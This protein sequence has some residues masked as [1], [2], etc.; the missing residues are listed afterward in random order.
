VSERN[1][2]TS[3]LP[4]QRQALANRANEALAK[5]GLADLEL[6]ANAEVWFKK[7]KELYTAGLTNCSVDQFRLSLEQFFACLQ[8]AANLDSRHPGIQLWL[9]ISYRDALGTEEDKTAAAKWLRKA[10]EQG[11]VEAQYALANI[12]VNSAPQEVA[13][14]MILYRNAAEQNHIDAQLALG[15]AYADGSGGSRN[16]VESA[17]WFRQA[18]E[19]NSSIGQYFLAEA[20]EH[21]RGVTQDN[22]AAANWYRKAAEQ[23][24]APAQYRLGLMYKKGD[25]VALDLNEAVK[26]FSMASDKEYQPAQF[27]IGHMCLY[28]EWF[29]KDYLK[30]SHHLHKAA[31]IGDS[32]DE[33]ILGV[34]LIAQLELAHM[35]SR[36]WGV[37][38][39]AALSQKWFQKSVATQQALNKLRPNRATD[40]AR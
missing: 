37:K 2:R 12:L 22:N 1:S 30:A 15:V 14:A 4:A 28:G 25:G 3:L 40:A 24:M 11:V 35:Y 32:L 7:A 26:W 23:D 34:A 36:G 27:Q 9:G 10:A 17:R 31:E 8:H 18:A 6:Q 13:E 29:T 20:F 38:K 33:E 39:D 5:R 16:L 19:Q 21:G